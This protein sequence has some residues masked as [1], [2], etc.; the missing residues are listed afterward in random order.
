MCSVNVVTC[1]D[2]CTKNY[3][4]AFSVSFHLYEVI[5]V[6]YLTIFVSQFTASVF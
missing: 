1:D 3:W 2:K 6:C 4:R 5:S